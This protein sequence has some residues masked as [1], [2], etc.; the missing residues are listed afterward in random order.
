MRECSYQMLLEWK[1]KKPRSCTFG[2]LYTALTAEKMNG[3]AKNMAKLYEQGQ[4]KSSAAD[5]QT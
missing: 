3:V 1:E 2:Q 5:T 4:F